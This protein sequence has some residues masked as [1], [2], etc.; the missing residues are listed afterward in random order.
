MSQTQQPQAAAPPRRMQRIP[1]PLESYEHPSRQLSAKR[2]VNLMPEPEPSDARTAAALVPT[3]GLIDTGIAFGSGPIWAM[4]ADRP[5]YM[6]VASGTGF[7]R[8]TAAAPDGTAASV[9]YLGE[10]GLPALQDWAVLQMTTIA[11]GPNAV[12]VCA[13]PNAFTCSHTGALHQ[14]S[15]TF[16][17][18]SSVT[19]LDGYFVFTA[20]S[21]ADQWFISGLLD[22][23]AFDALDFAS[24]DGEADIVRRVMTLNGELWFIGDRSVEVWYDAGAADFPFRRRQGAVIEHGTQ[25]LQ[26]CVI[27]DNSL[28]WVT[29]DGFVLRSV[30]YHAERVST[31][32]IEVIIRTG[33]GIGNSLMAFSYTQD[34]HTFYCL[35]WANR[36]LVY[37]CLTK[38]WHERSSSADGVAPWRPFAAARL[39]PN[40]YVGDRYSG[41]MFQPMPGQTTDDGV[42]IFRQA[43]F[44]PLWGGTYRA[45]ICKTCFSDCSF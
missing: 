7:Y 32:A 28:F 20:T 14:I 16:P 13:P 2:L 15:G 39:L 17:G 45:F 6:Y 19:Y 11:V 43:T 40:V 4:N 25:S 3:P 8:F 5:A 22:P 42:T 12:V 31:T 33:A 21:V 38:A 30:G 18:A 41:R 27:C 23:D 29:D 36:T 44:P 34:G 9:Q 1:I 35:N 37:D 24:A 10:I 26:T